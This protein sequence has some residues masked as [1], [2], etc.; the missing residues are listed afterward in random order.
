M[1]DRSYPRT[2]VL[3]DVDFRRLRGRGQASGGEAGIADLEAALGL[4]AGPPSPL[5]GSDIPAKIE[6][7]AHVVTTWALAHGELDRAERAARIARAALPHSQRPLLDLAAVL[8]AR[9]ERAAA[10]ALLRDG[11]RDEYASH[12]DGS[13]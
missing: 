3:V 12:D 2:D 13:L 10:A 8:D 7:V 1:T 5:A 6:D 11:M 4:V 9:G